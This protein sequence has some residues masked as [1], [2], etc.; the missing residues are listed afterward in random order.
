LNPRLSGL[1]P[2]V[3]KRAAIRAGKRKQPAQQ[4]WL[5]VGDLRHGLGAYAMR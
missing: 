2:Q 5:G 1:A 4:R 3:S